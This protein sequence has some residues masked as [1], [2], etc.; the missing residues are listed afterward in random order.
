M[1]SCRPRRHSVVT[2]RLTVTPDDMDTPR[3]QPSPP[4]SSHPPSPTQPPRPRSHS[5]HR[6]TTQSRPP[7]TSPLRRTPTS[8]LPR[9]TPPPLTRTPTTPLSRTPT[10]PMAR[11]PTSPFCREPTSPMGRSTPSP[12]S[13][14]S[15]SGRHFR[16]DVWAEQRGLRRRSSLLTV[17]SS[18]DT[19][20]DLHLRLPRPRSSSIAGPLRPPDLAR[21]LSDMSQRHHRGEDGGGSGDVSICSSFDESEQDPDATSPQYDPTVRSSSH[22][23]GRSTTPSAAFIRSGPTSPGHESFTTDSPRRRNSSADPSTGVCRLRQFS[24]TSRGGVVNRGDSFRPRRSASNTSVTS[25]VSSCSRERLPSVGSVPSTPG[26]SKVPTPTAPPQHRV[27]MIGAPG[28]GKSTLITQFMTSEYMCAYDDSP[29]NDEGGAERSVSVVLEGEEAELVFIHLQDITQA[30]AREGHADGWVVVYSISDRESFKSASTALGKVWSLGHV[31][32]R[33]VILVGNKTDLERTRV[34]NTA[35]GRTLATTYECK[36]IEVSAGFDHNVD[37]LLVGIL[38]QIRLKQ[39]AQTG[40]EGPGHLPSGGSVDMS[41]TNSVG[42][43][44]VSSPGGNAS[45]LRH[46]NSFRVKGILNKLLNKD[47]KAKSCE[48]LQVL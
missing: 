19:H 29:G 31:T 16:Y 14:R 20:S 40:G 25:T 3:R 35:E 36:F 12:V 6:Y 10:S 27:V 39:H 44:G 32:H 45:K 23:L 4:P 24:V 18:Y 9:S 2:L 8:P 21:Y 38:T 1:S 37:E 48:N 46:K 43:T 7:P 22:D 13:P 41:L 15:V 26:C 30:I 17:P 28:V 34:V 47:R 5:R 11:T 33:A 42:S